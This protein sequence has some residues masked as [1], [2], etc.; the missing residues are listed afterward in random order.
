MCLGPL[1]SDC[2]CAGFNEDSAGA[3]ISLT[4]VIKCILVHDEGRTSPENRIL[5]NGDSYAYY[6]LCN[7]KYFL[8]LQFFLC[9]TAHK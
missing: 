9:L 2:I 6:H 5:Q 1:M 8:N 3:E 7:Q 4:L